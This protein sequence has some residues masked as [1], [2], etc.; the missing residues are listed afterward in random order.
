MRRLFVLAAIVASAASIT[1]CSR[2]TA[3]RPVVICGQ[4]LYSG[5]EGLFVYS[6]Y[7][8]AV[9]PHPPPAG[10]GPIGATATTPI[11]FQLSVDC[12]RGA[13]FTVQPPGL[14]RID[15]EIRE[16]HG[17]IVAVALIGVKSGGATL[18][19]LSG[20]NSGWRTGFSVMG[21]QKHVR[22][23]KWPSVASF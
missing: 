7:P 18:T 1:A 20:K 13:Q 14:V 16:L 23:Q 5:A 9:G 2:T 21:S 8:N 17:G 15:K 4:T 12:D 22:P 3:A 10:Q 6:P 11:L 19:L